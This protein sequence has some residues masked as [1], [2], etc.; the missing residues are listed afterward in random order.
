MQLL[1]LEDDIDLGQ[2]VAEH[3]EAAGHGVH[4]CKFIAQA[5]LAPTFDMALL[6][7]QLADGDGLALLRDWRSE[8]LR[9]PVIALTARDQVS[10]R[11]RGLKAGADDYLV[12]PFDL[13]ELLA[14]IDAVSRRVDTGQR[15]VIGPA[16]LDLD[17]R[18]AQVLGQRVDLTA[19]EW[20]VVCCL[21][22]H[23]GRIYSR[24][25]IETALQHHCTHEAVS[26]SIEVIVSRLRKKLGSHVISTH[27]GLGYRLD[28]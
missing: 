3:L 7:L 15:I 4:W 10:D 22:R 11:I 16:T 13:D 17:L 20:G 23:R 2:A 21:A 12:K 26:N 8:G 18:L 9:Q 1:L 24:S 6:D 28:G 14:R 25:E 27:R 19:M 5:R